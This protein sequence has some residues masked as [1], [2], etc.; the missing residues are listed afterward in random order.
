MRVGI[1]GAGLAGLGAARTLTAAGH[2]TVIFEKSRGLGGRLAY[3]RVGPYLFDHGASSVSPR[4]RLLEKVMLDELPA[5]GRVKVVRPIHLHDGSR[6]TPGDAL[7]NS[8]S[9]WTWE[10]GISAL[11]KQLAAG[12][13]VR[14][15]TR[16]EGL[17]SLEPGWRMGGE[18][19]DAVILTAP[20]PQAADLLA[21]AG[22]P[23][24]LSR[25]A[26][27]MTLAVMFGFSKPFE[28]SWHAL[29]DSEQEHPLTWMTCES[30]KCPGRAPEGS[31][32]FVLHLSRRESRDRF[33]AD[34]RVIL[35][36]ALDWLQAL[37]G[38]GFDQ[39]EAASL[40]RW[41]FAQADATQ[42]FASVNLPG[43]TCVIAGDGLAGSRAELAYESGVD[44]ARLLMG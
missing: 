42:M 10:G 17:E 23:S 13:D 8:N 30:L 26:Y 38:K 43:A 29:L 3:R 32:A 18:E 22:L 25:V 40:H 16:I 28:A 34:E 37:I 7:K 33:E 21:S 36:H 19:F 11:A 20:A 39:P 24:P 44:A 4:G 6:I 15:Q 27:R 31:S 41:R 12:L 9:R 1:V 5:D 14:L 2:E 35:E